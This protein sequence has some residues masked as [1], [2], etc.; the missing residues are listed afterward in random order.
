[1]KNTLV[2]IITI[3]IV[4]IGLFSCKTENTSLEISNLYLSKRVQVLFAEEISA[5]VTV[6]DEDDD[7]LTY[8]WECTGGTIQGSGIEAKWTSPSQVG[9][10]TVKVT[11]SDGSESVVETKE[12][13]VVGSSFFDFYETS[14]LW[15][16][17]N[18]TIS[19]SGGIATVTSDDGVNSGSFGYVLPE[20]EAIPF[21]FKTKQALNT[22]DFSSGSTARMSTYIYFE[23]P[24]KSVSSDYLY[25]L[26]LHIS[27]CINLWVVRA[28]LYDAS[29]GEVVYQ[30]FEA[31]S[32]SNSSLIFT[33][34]NQF[35]TV[36]FS[37][38][39]DKI[40][41]IYI[42]GDV[43]F[44]STALNTDANYSY[45][46]KLRRVKYTVDPELILLID[47]FYLTNDNTILK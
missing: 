24:D 15:G 44:S 47:N 41:N 19:L 5:K 7:P 6:K 16:K 27:P 43:L 31:N 26:I 3:S 2:K 45:D 22:V 34:S 23:D 29:L 39:A 17:S 38:T 33:Q 30:D 4:L 37:I 36:S 10:Y 13:D 8:T 1:M 46:L 14:S 32:F 28:G 35:R 9:T 20:L 42:D 25:S 18:A 12:V 40:F 11:V 21:S